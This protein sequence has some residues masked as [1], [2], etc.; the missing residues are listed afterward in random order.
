[1]GAFRV[2][3]ERCSAQGGGG[4]GSG[5]GKKRG[6]K[7]KKNFI[8][9]LKGGESERERAFRESHCKEA[10]FGTP[11]LSVPETSFREDLS[12]KSR[13]KT[14]MKKVTRAFVSY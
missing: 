3:R 5:K 11:P 4:W 8:L 7:G 14:V 13:R 1:L 2:S 6:V 10:F 9:E 12:K